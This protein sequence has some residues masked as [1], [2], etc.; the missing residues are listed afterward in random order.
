MPL[1]DFLCAQGHRFEAYAQISEETLPCRT[2]QQPAERQFSFGRGRPAQ[3][4]IPVVVHRDAEGNI[5]YPGRSDEPAPPGYERVELRT[6][7]DVRQFEKTVN[8]KDY[9][10]W[11]EKQEKLLEAQEQAEHD[12]RSELF[13]QVK[14]E[15]GRNLLRL[16]IERSNSRPR[17]K[18]F[19]GFHVKIFSDDASRRR[20]WADEDT[21]WEQKR[22]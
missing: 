5:S 16:A 4:F 20:P 10:E 3:T 19:P 2:C 11:S 13:S 1:Y 17:K 15:F 14:T 6:I 8:E 22:Y 7:E 12:R 18:F 21:H 9:R